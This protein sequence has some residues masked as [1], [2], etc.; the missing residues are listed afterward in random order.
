MIDIHSH[1]IPNVDDG[2]ESIDESLKMLKEEVSMGIT[3]VICTPHYR[4]HMFT[5]GNKEI[6]LSFLNLKEA[7]KN[8]NLD[9][10]IYLGQEIY[11]HSLQGFKKTLEMLNNGEIYSYENTKYILLEFSYTDEI[12]ITEAAYMAIIKGYKPIIAHIE[13]Y[14]YINSIEKVQ[15]IIDVGALIQI[16]ASSVIGKDGMRTK[17]FI[18]KLINNNCVSFVSS[19][20]HFKRTNY[21]LKAYNYVVKK[22][23]KEIA[24]KIFTSNALKI[25]IKGIRGEGTK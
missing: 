25:L 22:H 16:N 23:S 17:K 2:S 12:D 8:N 6:Y 24:D 11:I 7:S 3:D 9:I 4:R 1:I 14:Q 21:M 18:R 20:I 13:R 10:N 5:T 19:D 15:E